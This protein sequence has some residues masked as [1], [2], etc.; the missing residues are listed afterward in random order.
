MPFAY[1]IYVGAFLQQAL[2]QRQVS[3]NCGVGKRPPPQGPI[4][5]MHQTRKSGFATLGD[6][7][8]SESTKHVQARINAPLIACDSAVEPQI[9]LGRVKGNTFSLH[10]HQS[11]VV[12]RRG[13]SLVGRLTVV[14]RGSVRI[15]RDT[16][17]LRI[18]IAYAILS[19]SQTLLRCQTP[20][21]QRF[22]V[23]LGHPT[24]PA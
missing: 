22:Y 21:L 24:P 9:C 13:V 19:F 8:L 3:S 18:K 2:R 7:V 20:P 4:P 17:A 11:Q 14:H 6:C 15:A 5:S 16:P 10:I 1:S 23:V 12:L